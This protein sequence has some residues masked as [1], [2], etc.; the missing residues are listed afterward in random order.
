MV[1]F[2]GWE[3]ADLRD[4]NGLTLQSLYEL[5]G[6]AW[7]A[8]TCTPRLRERW[9]PENPTLGQCSVTAFLVQDLFGGEV[10]GVPREAGGF[11]CFNV[12]DGRT[13]DL[14]SEQFGDEKLN[15]ADCPEQS[16]EAHFA[17]AEKR[18]RYLL[19]RKRLLGEYAVLL[20]HSGFNCC[21]AVLCA[22]AAWER[23]PA[24][25][26][27][28]GAAFGVG[29]GDMEGTC[30]ALC[31]AEMLLGLRLDAGRPIPRDARALQQ[32]FREKCGATICRE[33]VGAEAGIPLCAC[34]DC[35]RNAIAALEECGETA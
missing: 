8:D 5:L 13:F 3:G 31:A 6:G 20:K 34:D 25:L 24:T 1:K 23:D 21:Q 35:V 26:R 29:F 4:A 22:Y 14:T 17:R 32:A 12:I 18:Q 2:Y 19:L 33:M 28:V 7:R 9:S 30:G 27:R 10:R 15:Y 16:R 11:H